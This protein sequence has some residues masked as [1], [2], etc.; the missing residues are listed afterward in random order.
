VKGRVSGSAAA[1]VEDAL[2]V[3]MSFEVEVEVEVVVAVLGVGTPASTPASLFPDPA[4][5]LA[6]LL[7]SKTGNNLRISLSPNKSKS[8]DCRRPP[9]RSDRRLDHVDRGIRDGMRLCA[10]EVEAD[11][12]E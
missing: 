5:P 12:R 3:E 8:N 6:H 1:V 10:E 4:C 2:S 11:Q 7:A 9:T